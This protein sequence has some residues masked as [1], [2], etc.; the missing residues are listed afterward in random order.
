M[1]KIGVFVCHCGV[2]I[3]SKVDVKAVAE[4]ITEIPR[5]APGRKPSGEVE[6]YDVLH[7]WLDPGHGLDVSDPSVLLSGRG[8]RIPTPDNIS[9]WYEYVRRNFTYKLNW[10]IGSV[11]ALALNEAFE[12]KILA[13]SVDDWPSPAWTR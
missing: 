10:G 3:A 13:H 8:P 9:K 12:G 6:W 2:N 5:F 7:W 11:V 1:K 4:C